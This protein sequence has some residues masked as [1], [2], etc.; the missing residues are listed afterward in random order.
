MSACSS[1]IAPQNQFP[2]KKALKTH[3]REKIMLPAVQV[4]CGGLPRGPLFV[5]QFPH[6]FY[7]VDL[8]RKSVR[9]MT[10]RTPELPGRLRP[11]H[12]AG[13]KSALVSP[14]LCFSRSACLPR[15][16][17]SSFSPA[18]F[19]C[20]WQQSG[21]TIVSRETIPQCASNPMSERDLHLF[22]PAVFSLSPLRRQAP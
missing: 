17:C 3:R 12:L 5:C 8:W 7:F 1:R 13:H 15:A 4:L 9:R 11:R 16:H 19:R 21:G 6:N 18:G 20:F 14:S 22:R 10:I 2:R